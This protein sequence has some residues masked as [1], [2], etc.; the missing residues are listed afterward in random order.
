[1]SVESWCDSSSEWSAASNYSD[2]HCTI[3]AE[4]LRFISA[5]YTH[6]ARPTVRRIGVP[7]ARLRKTG[8]RQLLEESLQAEAGTVGV[9]S[10]LL[11][12]MVVALR[13]QTDHVHVAAVVVHHL[14]DPKNGAIRQALLEGRLT[15]EALASMKESELVNPSLREKWERQRTNIL[16]QK[17][18]AFV[19]QLTSAVTT[20]YTCPSCG[21]QR[22]LLRQRQADKQ[23]WA[24]DDA[25]PNLLTC[26]GCS[27][28]FRR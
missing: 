7:P 12:R 3:N 19:E 14:S 9:P 26:C 25:T 23:K 18:V 20:I 17:T 24:G 6:L 1:M 13:H 27:H 16:R 11:D 2:I 15:P 8:L 10:S 28:T 22:C 21:G 4:F 5:N